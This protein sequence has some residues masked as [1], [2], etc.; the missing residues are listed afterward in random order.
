LGLTDPVLSRI[1]VPNE[2]PG[3]RWHL[4]PLGQQLVEL[5]AKYGF[6]PGLYGKAIRGGDAPDWI[7]A[8]RGA[9]EIIDR[10]VFNGHD[11]LEN[12]GLALKRPGRVKLVSPPP[13]IQ[14]VRGKR[15]GS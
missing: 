12:L 3:H 7:Q 6:G 11:F 1:D 14:K 13:E 9:L 8:N 2:R 4:H 15:L 5:R 10:R